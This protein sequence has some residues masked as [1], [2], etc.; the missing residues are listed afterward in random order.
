MSVYDV[1]RR[2]VA[3][4]KAAVVWPVRAAFTMLATL[5]VIATLLL[6]VGVAFDIPGLLASGRLN[7]KA[8]EAIHNAMGVDN[9]PFLLRSLGVAAMFVL[10]CLGVSLLMLLR[11]SSGGIHMLRAVA[12]IGL[13]A[14]APFMV[15]SPGINWAASTDRVANFW[16]V[17][18]TVAERVSPD[19]ATRAAILLVAGV[20]LL[21]WPTRP[22]RPTRHATLPAPVDTPKTDKST[23]APATTATPAQ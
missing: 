5:L 13:V 3:V 18:Q 23:D 7:P 22:T 4:G 21:L 2:S 16:Q 10:A 12:G 17:W 20:L 9:W 1:A 8:P 6:A 19:V 14:W 15:A 11:R